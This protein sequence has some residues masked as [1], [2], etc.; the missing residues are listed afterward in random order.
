MV[1]FVYLGNLKPAPARQG[2]IF[3]DSGVVI[4]HALEYARTF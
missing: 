3:A 2:D 1:I 4:V